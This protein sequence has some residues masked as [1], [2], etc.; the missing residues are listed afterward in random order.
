MLA[1]DS[2][3]L[4]SRAS[5][6]ALAPVIEAKDIFAPIYE[7]VTI[8]QKQLLYSPRVRSHANNDKLIFVVLGILSGTQYMFDIN[9]KLRPDKPLLNAFGY[10]GCA[11]QS[12]IQD[13]LDA[14]VE[15][16]V[17]QLEQAISQIFA[18]QNRS[19][20]LRGAIASQAFRCLM[21]WWNQ[22]K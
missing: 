22:E 2:T 7:Q 5:L 19:Q 15:E 8:D 16:N 14:C 13:T 4:S 18:Q 10:E 12:V 21:L 1:S 17:I 3:A 20:A 9:V 11:D 6:A